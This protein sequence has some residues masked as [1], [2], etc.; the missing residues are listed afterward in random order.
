M[1]KF[2]KGQSGN[3][4]GRPRGIVDQRKLR[5]AI[6]TDIPDI[7]QALVKK[8]RDGDTGAARLLLD[9]CL[10]PL[11]ATEQPVAIKLPAG[12]PAEQARSIL[13]QIATGKVT[14]DEGLTLLTAISRVAEI[15]SAGAEIVVERQSQEGE[16]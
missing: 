16:Q 14:P 4:A 13:E 9:R 12:E 15:E 7:I 1:A 8:A 11:K 6:A 2:I 10:P 5:A 3:P